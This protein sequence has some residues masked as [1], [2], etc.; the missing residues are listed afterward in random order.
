M[1][2]PKP[3]NIVASVK[4]RLLNYAKHEKLDFNLVLKRYALE[5]FLYRL[6]CS[7]YKKKFILKGAMLFY[8]WVREKVRATK[9]L[10]L[11]GV[12]NPSEQHLKKIIIEVGKIITVND[13]LVFDRE[14]IRI[15]DIREENKYPGLRIHLV[16]LLGNSRIPLQIDV[17]YGDSI[18]PK[19]EEIQYPVILEMPE[20]KLLAYTRESTIA[21]KFEAMVKLGVANSRMKDYYDIYYLSNCFNF[22]GNI[23]QLAIQSTFKRRDTNIPERIP[24]GLSDDFCKTA[25][26]QLL[27]KGFLKRLGLKDVTDDFYIIVNEIRKFLLPVVSEINKNGLINTHW[28]YEKREWIPV[29]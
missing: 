14:S 28:S 22:V 8:V 18:E 20:P 4:Q 21:E 27:W 10:D 13:G 3:V 7:P 19:P 23:L 11:L 15:E 29:D 2:N 1:T 12:G 16:A 25:D 5:R 6:S 9:D 26:I 17:G 24:A